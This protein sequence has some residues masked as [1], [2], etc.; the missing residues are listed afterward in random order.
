MSTGSAIGFLLEG[1]MPSVLLAVT[2]ILVICWQRLSVQID[3]TEPPLLK[4]TVPYI[5][6]IIGILQHS[7]AYF[8][9]L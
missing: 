9:K 1:Y 2:T 6:H 7:T 8:E 5:G 3:P 4:P